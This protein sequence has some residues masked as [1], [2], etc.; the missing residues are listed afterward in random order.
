MG[1]YLAL[2]D[3]YGKISANYL[4][5]ALSGMSSAQRPVWIFTQN[6]QELAADLLEAIGPQKV[7]D[8]QTLT[9]PLENLLLMSHGGGLICSNSTL[10][11]W[12]FLSINQHNVVVPR[13]R[14]KTNAFSADMTLDSWRVLDVD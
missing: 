1:D 13:Y 4:L 10:S 14:G 11:W 5:Q 3:I 7:V 2:A 8:S 9:S 12:A 6:R